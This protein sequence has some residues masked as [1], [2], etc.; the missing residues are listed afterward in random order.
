VGFDTIVERALAKKPEERFQTAREFQSAVLQALQGKAIGATSKSK[1]F[2]AD[3]TVAP[4]E[5]TRVEGTRSKAATSEIRRAPVVSIPPETLAE[6]ERSLSRHIGPLAKL[7][8]KQGQGEAKTVEEFFR[9]LAE[10][11]PDAEEQVAFLKKMS[12]IKA[13]VTDEKPGAPPAP[14]GP[15]ATQ[16]T[17][18][19][20]ATRSS[21]TPEVLSTAERRLASY[22]GPLA[23]V[24]IKEAA[25][26]S[27]NLKELYFKLAE[28]IDSEDE[29]RDFLATLGK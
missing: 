19:A 10:N 16:L 14:A 25:V 11:I 13:S 18:A 21:F 24:L 2:Q 1:R 29:R 4:A 22:V 5:A 26:S 12:T 3:R 9:L 27:V 6:I 23:R 20:A 17:R 15:S 7:L 8:I 28:H